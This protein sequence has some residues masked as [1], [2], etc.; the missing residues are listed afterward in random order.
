MKEKRHIL[1]CLVKFPNFKEKTLQ[2][3]RKK[4]RFLNDFYPQL[5]GLSSLGEKMLNI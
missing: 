1:M 3:F 2:V 5:S 4:T